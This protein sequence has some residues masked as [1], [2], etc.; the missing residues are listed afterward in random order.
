M[1]KQGYV[2]LIQAGE[3]F[4]FKIG[5]S[6][7][8]VRRIKEM[9]VGSPIALKLLCQK[10][11]RD[12]CLQESRWHEIFGC[13]RKHGE[14]FDLDEKQL[15]KIVFALKG[16]IGVHFTKRTVDNLRVG[17]KYYISWDS[18]KV[19]EV[20]LL[21]LPEKDGHPTVSVRRLKTGS[22]HSLYP[23]E[24]RESPVSAIFN[25]VTF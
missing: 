22:I 25:R 23:D 19:E 15:P 11:C 9:Q 16:D 8:P 21:E 24:I 5:R 13:S 20:I 18:R 2:Y 14:W 12:M 17:E 4:R 1:S 3:S 7:N 6:V 10:K